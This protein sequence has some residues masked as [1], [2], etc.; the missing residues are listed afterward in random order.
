MEH[1]DY[2]RR[3][4]FGLVAAGT[5]ALAVV[6]LTGCP[7]FA[8]WVT[9]AEKDLPTIVDIAGIVVSIVGTLSG[10]PE[11][12]PIA[13][14]LITEAVNVFVEAL[15]ALTDAV[16]AYKAASNAGTLAGVTAALN[17]VEQDAPGVIKA[18]TQ[19]PANIISIITSAIGTAIQLL[20]AIQNL[21]PASTPVATGNRVAVAPAKRVRVKN[22][23]LPDSQMLK[24][25]FNSTL[26]VYGYGQ[27]SVK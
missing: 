2:T 16:T 12:T 15:K 24:S 23:K 26:S 20:S 11:L 7:T 6:P 27:F 5:V 1:Q 10:N 13:V 19:A 22:V 4:I 3:S 25:G 9:T 17:A 18:I 21:I 8:S 14:G